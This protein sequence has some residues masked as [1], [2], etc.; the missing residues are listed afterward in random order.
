MTKSAQ[1]FRTIG[2]VEKILGVQQHV[3]RY[4]ESQIPEIRP[5]RRGGRSR[6]YRPEDTRL[7]A[8]IKELIDKNGFTIQAVQK[9]LKNDGIESVASPG[10]V[11]LNAQALDQQTEQAIADAARNSGEPAQH[12]CEAVVVKDSPSFP[13]TAED[14][15][16]AEVSADS[17]DCPHSS[18]TDAAAAVP[19]ARTGT[20]RELLKHLYAR[21]DG[22]RKRMESAK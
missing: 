8:G 10:P 4:W 19:V 21:L 5:V 13:E 18:S 9:K 3:L 15:Y 6:L 1:A 7:L 11:G 14:V 12:S 20:D 22:L 2:E 16:S 17:G